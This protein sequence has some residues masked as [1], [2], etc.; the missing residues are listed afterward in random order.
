MFRLATKLKTLK[1]SLKEWAKKDRNST[2]HN[3]NLLLSEL[4]KIHMDID[5]DPFNSQLHSAE[6][7]TKLELE[8]G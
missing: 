6:S 7:N 8:D 4:H 3:I 1:G 2:R 5:H